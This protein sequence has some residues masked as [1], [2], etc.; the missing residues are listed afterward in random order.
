MNRCERCHR[1]ISNQ[2]AEY[3]PVCAKILGV[4]EDV[5]GVL[6]DEMM[7]QI[8]EQIFEKMSQEDQNKITELKKLYAE[9]EKSG[10]YVAMNAA[11]NEAARIREKY[12]I[13]Y[14][15]YDGFDYTHGGNVK[16][17]ADTSTWSIMADID[18]HMRSAS[19]EEKARLKGVKEIVQRMA[20]EGTPVLDGMDRLLSTLHANAQT[21]TNVQ[22]EMKNT[23]FP[24]LTDLEMFAPSCAYLIGKVNKGEWD[25]KLPKND[26]AGWRVPYNTMNGES[27]DVNNNRNW[28]NWIYID[29][30]LVG[31]DKIGNINMAY[32]GYKMGLPEYVYNNFET[33]DKD[34]AKWV[35]YG[36]ELAKEGY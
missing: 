30:H 10:D 31:A 16:K 15:S 35:E 28:Q 1:Q 29:G 25:Y 13:S 4:P 24:P 6:N 9:A 23:T 26:S 14:K 3:G 2:A 22:N 18:N 19:D 20:E 36:I 33:R 21:A 7:A 11:H 17:L 12:D 27:M 8:E 34:D 32:V 5:D